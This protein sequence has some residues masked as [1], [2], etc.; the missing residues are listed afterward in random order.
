M[1][2]NNINVNIYADSGY[3]VWT[4]AAGTA[5]PTTLPPTNPGSAFYEV[6]LLSATGIT[7][8]HTLSESKIFDLAGSLV[9]IARNQEERPWTFE[10]LEGNAIVDGLRYPGSSVTTTGATAEVQTITTTGASGTWTPVLAGF[11]T[12]PA[13]SQSASTPTTAG[14][15]AALILAWGIPVTVTGTAGSSYVV[16]FPVGVGNITQMTASTTGVATAS[17][18][19]TTPGV[20]GVNSRP[21]GSGT[22]RNLR[23]WAVDLT[24]GGVH[25]RVT[26]N[27]GE[28]VWTGTTTYSGGGASIYQFTLQPFKDTNGNYYTILSDDPADAE[29]FA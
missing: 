20:T 17:V 7:E 13:Q 8:G 15:Q 25:K 4:A 29:T 6:G 21:V 19:T 22:S 10:A 5:L 23:V 2:K 12:V 28:A 24:D 26:I 27:S 3:A 9:R 16:T 18:A 14:L 1:A 11:G